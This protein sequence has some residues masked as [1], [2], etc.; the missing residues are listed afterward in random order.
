M[1]AARTLKRSGPRFGPWQDAT[2]QPQAYGVY[3]RREWA[4]T[5]VMAVWDGEAWA[6]GRE[7]KQDALDAANVRSVFQELPWR[8]VLR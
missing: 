8:E 2:T 7:T 3:Q 4:G 1:T 5:V 6:M